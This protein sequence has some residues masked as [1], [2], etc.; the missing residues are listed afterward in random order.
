MLLGLG[1]ISR[2]IGSIWTQTHYSNEVSVLPNVKSN[3]SNPLMPADKTLYPV[4]PVEGDNIG[5]STIPALNW[6][7]AMMEGTGEK[8]LKKGVG[9][10]IQSV[11]PGEKA[12]CVISGHRETVFSQLDKLKVGDLVIMETSAGTFTYEVRST[13]IV[14]KDDKTVIGFVYS[15]CA[16]TLNNDQKQQYAALYLQVLLQFA[17]IP[18]AQFLGDCFLFFCALCFDK[19]NRHPRQEPPDPIRP[20][21]STNCF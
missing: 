11:L 3:T 8:E 7:V 20:A 10:F 9:H 21:K 12:N 14:H 19:H 13:K 6:K 16:I 1:L 2:P 4:Y 17:E 5:S 18:V 15:S